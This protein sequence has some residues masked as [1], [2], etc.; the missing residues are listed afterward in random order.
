MDKEE[1]LKDLAIKIERK[2]AVIFSSLI[3]NGHHEVA[4]K[5]AEHATELCRWLRICDGMVENA[6]TTVEVRRYATQVEVQA[7]D[8]P[9]ELKL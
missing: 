1:T 5:I 2:G 3:I 9:K 8:P 6:E 4:G 7:T